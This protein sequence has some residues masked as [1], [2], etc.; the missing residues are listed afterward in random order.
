MRSIIM[1]V[2]LAGRRLAADGVPFVGLKYARRVLVLSATLTAVMVVGLLGYAT[3]SRASEACFEGPNAHCLG[4]TTSLDQ[5]KV[6]EPLT[7]TIR[8]FCVPGTICSNAFFFGV[9]D[10]LPAGLD[11]VRASVTGGLDRNAHCVKLQVPT[12]TRG[13]CFPVAINQ[14]T[15]FVATIEVIPRQCGTFTN[16]AEG[17]GL[18]ASATFTV[19]RCPPPTKEQCKTGGWSD[20]EFAFP[21]QTTCESAVNRQNRQ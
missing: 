12:G 21:N 20:P 5:V 7:F 3:P 2:T 15:P 10:T 9:D 4:K 14:D 16:T 13:D 18:S 17:V 11:F 19:V 6:G 8:V 1:L